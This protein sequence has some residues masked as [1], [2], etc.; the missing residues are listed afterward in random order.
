MAE[1]HASLGV[2]VVTSKVVRSGEALLVAVPDE[3]AAALRLTEGSEVE[4]MLD[5]DGQRLVVTPTGGAGS[6]VSE[7]FARRVASFI[8]TYRPALEALS[9]R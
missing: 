4:V 9:Q 2:S 3:V 5:A 6:G 8:E 7:D 1:Y